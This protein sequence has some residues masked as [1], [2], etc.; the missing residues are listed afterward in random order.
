[1]PLSG[2]AASQ[3]DLPVVAANRGYANLSNP[4]YILRTLAGCIHVDLA[5]K[6]GWGGERVRTTRKKNARFSVEEGGDGERVSIAL[7]QHLPRC[8]ATML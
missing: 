2:S 8:L 3:N 1:M 5:K 7:L 6:Q 4:C